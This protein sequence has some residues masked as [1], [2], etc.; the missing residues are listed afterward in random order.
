M[1]TAQ[2]DEWW[3]DGKLPNHNGVLWIKGEPGAGKSTLM[4]YTLERCKELYPDHLIVAF[5]FNAQGVSL[6]KSHLGMMRSIVH[7][8]FDKDDMSFKAFLDGDDGKAI[9][10]YKDSTWKKGQLKHIIRRLV[11]LR[12]RRS[13]PLLLFID[14]LDECNEEDLRDVVRFLQGLSDSAVKFPF[15]MRICLSSRH[16]LHISMSKNL[17][18]GMGYEKDIATYVQATM[19]TKDRNLER[20]VCQKANGIF[21]WVAL[22]VARLN[23][24]HDEGRP[25]KMKI[26]LNQLPEGLEGLFSSILEEVDTEAKPEFISILQWVLFSKEPL[27]PEQLYIATIDT[28][29]PS[30]D[31]IRRRLLSSSNGLVNLFCSPRHLGGETVQVIHFS[32]KDFICRNNRLIK[33]D[34]TLEPDPICASHD[35]LWKRCL[36]HIRNVR[37]EYD[38]SPFRPYA[39]YHML[40]HANMAVSNPASSRAFEHDIVQWLTTWDGWSQWAKLPMTAVHTEEDFANHRWLSALKRSLAPSGFTHEEIAPVHIRALACT[41]SLNLLRLFIKDPYSANL[42]IGKN[43]SL[44]QTASCL[45]YDEVVEFLLNQGANVNAQGGPYGN[46]LQAACIRGADKI[47][48]L[49]LDTGANVNA[50]GGEY[51]N[52]LQAACS[53]GVYEIARLLLDNGANVNAQGGRYDNALQAA[54]H[55]GHPGIWQLLIDNGADVKSTDNHSWTPLTRAADSKHEEAPRLLAQNSASMR[56]GSLDDSGYDTRES[57][58]NPIHATKDDLGKHNPSSQISEL[59]M[60]QTT[61]MTTHRAF[62]GQTMT[63]S[64]N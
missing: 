9:H 41:G 50:Q 62:L 56:A 43:G 10:R 46:V 16:Y 29:L 14:A 45:G 17:E 6:E 32:V 18:L 36:L 11:E 35:R 42:Q 52:A 4:K 19:H 44:L 49:L 64:R 55:H 63:L 23:K 33:L 61:I 54:L 28:S 7:Q 31:Y 37:F 22:V 25:D 20:Q 21:L 47:V 34:P 48:R 38:R 57:L 59:T 15:N 51:G 8:I 40:H 26:M 30:L 58:T 39:T 3:D 27:T 24:A 13:G 2:F 60:N 1:N 5:F 12:L 53:A